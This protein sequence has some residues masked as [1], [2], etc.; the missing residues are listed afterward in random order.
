MVKK[1]YLR[2]AEAVIAIMITFTMLTLF[3]HSESVAESRRVPDMVL[4]TLK[5]N[6]DF[7][8]CVESRNT[9]CINQTLAD[10]IPDSYDF[11]F[12]YTDDPN[13]PVSVGLPSKR[14]FANSVML[15]GN[16]TN[17]TI[18]I[19]RLFYWTKS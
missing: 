13:S 7:R 16:A 9:A 4:D 10:Q 5:D 17:S 12:N 18:T 14:I 6:Q 3:I 15:T 19:F 1:A 2:T 11:T 8:T